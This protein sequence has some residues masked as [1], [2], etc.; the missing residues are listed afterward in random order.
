MWKTDAA[1]SLKTN[2]NAI[3][4][5]KVKRNNI[6]LNWIMYHLEKAKYFLREDLS[7]THV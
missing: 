7:F 4:Q 3:E 2:T 6:Q 1:L 5:K